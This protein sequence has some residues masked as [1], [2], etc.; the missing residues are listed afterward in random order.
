MDGRKYYE[1]VRAM[2][3][4]RHIPFLFVSAY[5]DEY[6][7]NSVLEP[8]IEGFM[9]KNETSSKLLAWIEYLSTPLGKRAH[10]VRPA[11]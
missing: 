9:K 6:A 8:Y 11:E 5:E 7:R 4:Y 10:L 2:E 1:A 3:G